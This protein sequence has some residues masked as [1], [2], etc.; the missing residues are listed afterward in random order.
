MDDDN[1][2][3]FDY[4]VDPDE[5]HIRI[6]HKGKEEHTSII[7]GEL[8]FFG[9]INKFEV[10]ILNPAQ[11]EWIMFNIKSPKELKV[12]K[13]PFRHVSP[14]RARVTFFPDSKSIAIWEIGDYQTTDARFTFLPYPPPE[15]VTDLKDFYTVEV[16]NLFNNQ[17]LALNGKDRLVYF[18]GKVEDKIRFNVIDIP[19]KK[20]TKHE[21]EKPE[22]G[23]EYCLKHVAELKKG[24]YL[25]S[26]Q[27][28]KP[29]N[30]YVVYDETQPGKPLRS[31]KTQLTDDVDTIISLGPWLYVLEFK[32]DGQGQ[33][34]ENDLT[35][36][37]KETELPVFKDKCLIVAGIDYIAGTT[38]D[39]LLLRVES[40]YNCSNSVNVQSMRATSQRELYTH[41]LKEITGNKIRPDMVRHILDAFAE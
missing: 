19:A 9:A 22:N 10:F 33:P 28:M 21:I 24:V 23:A 37:S 27:A 15:V 1:V 3:V 13:F 7:P 6:F 25:L 11:G 12:G 4:K 5:T 38:T 30:R 20:D 40:E 36:F 14:F 17:V 8:I 18:A 16:A 2:V 31:F 35:A 41:L 29:E 39:Q 32:V 26:I 34:I